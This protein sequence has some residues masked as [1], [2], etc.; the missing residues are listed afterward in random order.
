MAVSAISALPRFALSTVPTPLVRAERLGRALGCP[1]LH[2]KR[3][4]LIGFAVAGGKTRLLEHLIGDALEQSCT[5]L[6]TGGGAASSYCAGAAVAAAMAGLRCVLVI[7]GDV[8]HRVHPNLALAKAA[9]ATVHF[10]GKASRES[11]DAALLSVEADLRG[12][13]ERPYLVPRGGASGI[14]A[15]GFA[16][17]AG[18]LKAQ[19][20]DTGIATATVLVATGSGTTQAGLV[21]GSVVARCDWQVVGAS[22]SRPPAEARAQ[23]QRLATEVTTL[24]GAPAPDPTQIDLRDA[25]GDG[26]GVPSAA[27]EQMARLALHTAGLVLD[28]IFTAKALAIL[29]TLIA[30]GAR[31]PIVFWHT[32]GI[33]VALAHLMGEDS[34]T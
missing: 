32:G 4:D 27:G 8:S 31:D 6:L 13:G 19:L 15:A 20:A 26:Y 30:G 33:S 14:A 9:G 18:E 11:V 23:V 22:V 29:P 10:T 12:C 5:T 25:R 34:P 16:N 3:D 17:A 24:L 2:V 28:P 7:Y 21:A 1:S